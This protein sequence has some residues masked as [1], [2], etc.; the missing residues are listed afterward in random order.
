MLCTLRCSFVSLFAASNARP[1]LTPSPT[2]PSR[3]RWLQVREREREETPN[4]REVACLSLPFF[5][6]AC[7]L[8]FSA[9]SIFLLFFQCFSSLLF[10]GF[11]SSE[12]RCFCRCC[13]MLLLF[14]C[15]LFGLVACV[16][17]AFSPCHLTHLLT[18]TDTSTYTRRLLYVKLTS[19]LLTLL[20]FFCLFFFC[21]F[22]LFSL[23]A[24][25]LCI[26]SRVR[27]R[28]LSNLFGIG[29]TTTKSWRRR[30]R[31]RFL[32]FPQ[33]LCLFIFNSHIF[34][35]STF[36]YSPIIDVKGRSCAP[37]A[38]FH[39]AFGIIAAVRYHSVPV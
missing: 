7:P 4:E 24:C 17:F 12:L 3:F 2:T 15:L 1:P 38:Q 32:Y 28:C 18:H 26:S 36:S 21:T 6:A 14:V 29:A 5:W 10:F 19:S 30:R 39:I 37:P 25:I 11:C 31:H 13:A 9:S 20:S 8:L 22:S 16:C 23:L 27:F 35:N 33:S 34:A